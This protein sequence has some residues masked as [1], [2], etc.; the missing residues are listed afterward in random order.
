MIMHAK[1]GIFGIGVGISRI[2]DILYLYT[3]IY[4]I[5][6]HNIYIYSTLEIDYVIFLVFD[7][8]S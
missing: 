8:S 7:F 1:P 3:Y 6:T 5:S 4:I 2:V